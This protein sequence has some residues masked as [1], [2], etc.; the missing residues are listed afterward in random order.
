VTPP[1]APDA[2]TD[3]Q[4]VG[5]ILLARGYIKLDQLEQ[6][7]GSQQQSGKPLGQVLVEAGAITRLELASAL[8]EQWSDTA[9]WLGPPEG[10]KAAPKRARPMVEE[11]N[12]EAREA[13]FAQQLQDAVV[14]L[15]RRF[16][17]FEPALT[18]LKLRIE[19][20]EVGGPDKLL[21]RIEVVQDGVTALARR[22]DE[23]TN[24]VERAFAS[25]EASS[26]DLAGEIDALSSRVDRAAERT[27]VDDI[28][29]TLHEM[30]VRP[31]TDPALAAQIDMLARR[32]EELRET[33]ASRADA[34]ALQA[35]RSALDEL[36]ER[37]TQSSDSTMLDELQAT[38]AALAS[39][40][41]ADPAVAER[42]EGLAA[43]IDQLAARLDETAGAL[44]ARA[45]AAS[46][47]ELRATV[48][49]L[50]GR[51]EADPALAERLEELTGRIEALAGSD[52]L[53]TVR[54]AVEEIAGRPTADPALTARIDELAARVDETVAALGGR[55]EQSAL[56]PLQEALDE[57]NARVGSLVDDD[58]LASIRSAVDEVAARPPVAPELLDQ[59]SELAARV[60]LLS[61][62]TAA[63]DDEAVLALRAKIDDLAGRST[64]DPEL[65]RRLDNVVGR[66]DALHARVE[67]VASRLESTRDEGTLEELRAAV[68]DLGDRPAGDPQLAGTIDSIA[69][70]VDEL[71]TALA[72]TAD[73]ATKDD[74]AAVK[75]ELD[76]VAASLTLVDDLAE[77]IKRVEETVPAKEASAPDLAETLRAELGSQIEALASRTDGLAVE[78]A[79]AVG[80]LESERVALEARI[81]AL[82]T[83]LAEARLQ[84]PP[85]LPAAE[86]AKAAATEPAKTA[87]SKTKSKP[88]E[89]AAAGVESELERLRMAVE[90][91][92]MHLSERE[93]AIA[94]MLRSRSSDAK[95]E[96]LAARLADLE[97]GGGGAG[98]NG[99]SAKTGTGD[100]PLGGNADMNSALR[101]LAARL[102]GA[103][104]SAKADREKV[105]TQLE[106][107]A[108]SIDWRVRRLESG[109]TETPA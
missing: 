78:T 20:A 103:E 37:V 80:A 82:A 8:A 64:A 90:R 43:H 22:L 66:L 42:L 19:S 104:Q 62:D 17:L 107:M 72:D 44:G 67:E 25:V 89:P 75:A 48:T 24:G 4:T 45:D 68:Q 16:A 52:A 41:H 31:V 21:D 86:P 99:S 23:L 47:D 101:E 97:Q 54:H 14:E 83:E 13:G 69:V 49:E 98:G 56:A 94:D 77:R 74:I 100:A 35:L 91:I 36:T 9:T 26:G 61:A 34:D 106:R 58:A 57:L 76:A 92:N 39:R 1:T 84:A 3:R 7:L 12:L 18:D 51:P 96:E 30:T 81:D 53:E 108:S 65:E 85:A 70:R 87:T 73:Q 95:V 11:E 59:L 55:A 2:A 40:P 15:A 50:A 28:R 33:T 5:D 71:T 109:E 10:S 102:E 79:G 93:R 38:V 46:L 88:D 6:A 27:S 105:L 60:E 29:S 32:L 63:S